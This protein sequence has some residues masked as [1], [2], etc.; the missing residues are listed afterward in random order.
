MAPPLGVKSGV[1]PV[2]LVSALQLHR[3]ELAFFDDGTYQPK[4]E[5]VHFERLVKTPERFSVTASGA[6]KG[7]R[8]DLLAALA[9]AL[10]VPVPAGRA[11]RLLRVVTA[12]SRPSGPLEQLDA[13]PV[14]EQ[15]VRQRQPANARPDHAY[16]HRPPASSCATLC[17]GCCS[18]S[19]V[20]ASARRRH[21][22][23]RH[24]AYPP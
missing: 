10:G 13:M 18:P 22:Q 5:A 4:L 15:P 17:G 12:T 1:V 2:L 6:T 19:Q 11:P 23:L 20:P 7:L 24:L 21:F 3:D 8:A 16:R 14:G 9:D